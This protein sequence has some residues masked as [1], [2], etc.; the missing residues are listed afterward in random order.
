M[1][2]TCMLP[3]Q[4]L[5]NSILFVI[6]LG[7]AKKRLEHTVSILGTDYDFA[8]D[9]VRVSLFGGNVTIWDVNGDSL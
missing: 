1:V 4:G 9:E 3:M 8:I 7:R 5:L 2:T 6:L